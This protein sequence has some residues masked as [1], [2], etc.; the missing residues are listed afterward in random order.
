MCTIIRI[1]G[2]ATTGTVGAAANAASAAAAA[3][4]LNLRPVEPEFFFV[5]KGLVHPLLHSHTFT[6]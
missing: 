3:A 1:A 5:P 4:T 2:S 6:L